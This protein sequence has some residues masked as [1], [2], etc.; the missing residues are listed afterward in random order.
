MKKLKDIYTDIC[1]AT[2][3]NRNEIY[4]HFRVIAKNNRKDLEELTSSI[5]L[6]EDSCL[7]EIYE[8]LSEDSL[9]YERFYIAELERL[10]QMAENEPN[11]LNI[12][13]TLE[14]YS[15]I[16]VKNIASLNSAIK[17]HLKNVMNSSHTPIRRISTWML[18]EFIDKNSKEEIA[19]LYEKLTNDTDW[20]VRNMAS[21]SLKDIF[22]GNPNYDLKIVD[23][24]KTYVFSKSVLNFVAL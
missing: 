20:R 17:A 13:E 11:N 16:A 5:T 19:L 23:K 18:G 4:R 9:E 6:N 21:I 1:S 3:E 7:F 24:I 8:A 10:L 12:Y 14:A 22:P 2:S 15:F